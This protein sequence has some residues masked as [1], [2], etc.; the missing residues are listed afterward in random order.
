MSSSLNP[1]LKWHGT[2]ES[3]FPAMLSAIA[4]ARNTIQ[5]ETYIYADGKIGRQFLEALQDAAKRGVRVRVLVD[6]VGSWFLPGHFFDPLRAVGAEVRQ[7]NPLHLWRFGVRDHRKLLL[8]DETVIFIGGFNLAD[9]Y[10][11]DGIAR[12][13]CDLG[14]QIEN[15]DLAKKLSTSFDGLFTLAGFHRRP[16]LRL[17]A[18]KRRRK[19][20]KN[21]AAELLLT[22]PGHGA[23]PFQ[24]SLYRDLAV[25]RDVRIISAY[26]LPTRR[27]RHELL[28][29]IRRGGR[30]QLI[31]AGKSD[32]LI[33]QLAARSRYRRLLKAGV[34][35]YEY[36]PQVLHAKLILADDT[37]YVGSSNLDVRSLNLNYELMLRLTD[38]STAAGA[39]E[40]FAQTLKHSQRIEWPQWKQGQTFWS[41]WKNHWAN[42]L[43]AR[44][45]PL[46]ALHQF[47]IL[48]K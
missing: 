23:S 17:R 37:I 38:K 44:V 24:T 47:R 26:F 20:E 6:A 34:E 9:E 2:G 1:V 42:F 21:P 11:G 15:P 46:I 12:G 43:L 22:Q 13:W 48:K 10:D 14:A 25:A 7:F 39:R 40:L 4:A 41:R 27:V 45:D 5:L 30:V 28:R 19:P 36:Q 29:V 35:L 32:I 33:S 16:L 18:F 8:C 3:V 31:L